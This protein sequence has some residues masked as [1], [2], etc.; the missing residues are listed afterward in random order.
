MSG[1]STSDKIMHAIDEKEL[2]HYLLQNYDMPTAEWWEGADQDNEGL[3]ELIERRPDKVTSDQEYSNSHPAR[4]KALPIVVLLKSGSYLAKVT[5]T[6][7]PLTCTA[8]GS[9]STGSYID[10]FWDIIG[11]QSHISVLSIS[12]ASATFKVR[13]GRYCFEIRY[14]QCNELVRRYDIQAPMRD[15]LH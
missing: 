7:V 9:I 8:F 3:R 11:E 15:L 6:N 1:L 5:A 12:E 10:I 2:E 4:S 13:V 14:F